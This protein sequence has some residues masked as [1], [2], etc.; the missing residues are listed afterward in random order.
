MTQPPPPPGWSPDPYGQP[1]PYGQPPQ[2]APGY[3]QQQPLP[4]QGFPGPGQ[5]GQ[6]GQQPEYAPP[7]YLPPGFRPADEQQ[8][9][10]RRRTGLIVTLVVVLVAVGAGIGAYYLFFHKSDQQVADQVVSG[11]AQSYTSLAHSMSAGDLAKVKTYLCAKDQQAVQT[12]YDSERQ[13][14][15]ADATFSLTTTGTRTSGS[16]GSFSLVIKDK[17]SPPVSHRGSLVKQGSQWLVCNT[18]SP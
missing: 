2:G 16:T 6:F 13:T 9:P 10:K 15:G 5:Q 8:P 18:L 12:I 3:G 1:Q 17:N 14:G 4:G 11:F 7:G